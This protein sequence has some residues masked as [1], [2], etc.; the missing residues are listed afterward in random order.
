MR[1]YV[2]PSPAGGYFVKLTGADAPIS[3][4]DT[5]DEAL[6]RCGAY[7]VGA[8]QHATSAGSVHLRDGSVVLVRPVRASDKPLFVAGF[9][10]LSGQSRY[11]RFFDHRKGLSP[12]E[13]EFFTELDGTRQV[14]IG[15]LDP[16]TGDGLAVARYAR[17]EDDPDVAEA[18]IVVID[19]WQRRGL[20]SV[21]LRRLVW[22][23]QDH[24]IE[25]FCATLLTGNEVMLRMFKSIGEVA[26]T[27][28]EAGTLQVDVTL[29]VGDGRALYEALRIAARFDTGD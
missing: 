19:A 9:E 7:R 29:G 2:E 12:R 22:H 13:L 18:A 15:A 16:Y 10:R 8:Q 25:R 1:F 17:L 11:Q 3:H 20:G 14:A 24:G 27:A 26:V 6:A 23:A 4:H 5:E 28:R 21:L